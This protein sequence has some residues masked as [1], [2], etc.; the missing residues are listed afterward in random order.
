[1]IDF[2]I[3]VDSTF[4]NMTRFLT[5]RTPETN[6]NIRYILSHAY[7]ISIKSGI[8]LSISISVLVCNHSSYAYLINITFLVKFGNVPIPTIISNYE[9]VYYRYYVELSSNNTIFF[10]T[11]L[12]QVPPLA[13]YDSWSQNINII[14][15][16]TNEPRT[17]AKN[18]LCDD[19]F[20]GVRPGFP[21]DQCSGNESPGSK[22]MET[23]FVFEFYY[24][25]SLTIIVIDAC[26]NIYN[27]V[28]ITSATLTLLNSVNECIISVVRLFFSFK[29][30]L[31]S[32]LNKPKWVCWILR[33][34]LELGYGFNIAYL[35]INIEK[36]ITTVSKFLKIYRC[37]I[38]GS[39][40]LS[41]FTD[42]ISKHSIYSSWFLLILIHH[43]KILV[44]SFSFE[45]VRCGK[46]SFQLSVSSLIPFSFIAYNA[47][48]KPSSLET[49]INTGISYG[50]S[51]S[52][53]LGK[54]F[55][56]Q[57]LQQLDQKVKKDCISMARYIIYI[58]KDLLTMTDPGLERRHSTI[59]SE[60]FVGHPSMFA[61]YFY[62][63]N[64]KKHFHFEP[65][66]K[67]NV[68]SY[69]PFDIGEII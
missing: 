5:Y 13:F 3:N 18:I 67:F 16:K 12:Y 69:V 8:E 41:S 64:D 60:L 28:F 42:S 35:Y 20:A 11:I 38:L 54:N 45:I 56:L 23:H 34:G 9:N 7:F 15:T 47:R 24:I 10:E 50:T 6:T 57:L 43:Q 30:L 55:R 53:I 29:R 49:L 52:G 59:S 1:M 61:I 32:N 40:L 48:S 22:G 36:I 51:F 66:F 44:L 33:N 17:D 65:I 39:N 4:V 25:I 58:K 19:S 21:F 2:K 14:L 62:M 46:Y 31:Q 68:S 37:R 26:Y 27:S 63:T